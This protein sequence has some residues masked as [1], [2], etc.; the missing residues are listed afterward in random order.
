MLL[1]YHLLCWCIFLPSLTSGESCERNM[2]IANCNEIL[3]YYLW[4]VKLCVPNCE[5]L[6]F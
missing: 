6:S 1:M 2:A 4:M 3:S 5:I